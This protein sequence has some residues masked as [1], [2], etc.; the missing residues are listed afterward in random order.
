MEQAFGLIAAAIGMTILLTV[1]SG[2]I[3]LVFGA[4]ILGLAQSRFG[5][6]RVIY[7][8]FV[9]VVRGVPALVWL[10]ITFFGLAELGIVIPA[11]P[12]AIIAL[13]VIATAS[14]AEIYRGGLN[15]IRV[16]Q[17]EAGWAIGLSRFSLTKDVVFPQLLRAVSPTV[18]TYFVGLLKDSA[19]AS[20][21]GVSEI[22]FVTGQQVTSHGNGLT[23]YLFAGLL[24]LALSVPLGILSR[25]V[26]G[27]LARR[28]TVV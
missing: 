16:G 26:S 27:R 15:A 10:F 4:L 21:I 7:S 20:V 17:Y 1:V 2:G 5:V 6:F 22:V 12:S 28:Y 19:L 23:L 13:G 8:V 3:G 18:A 24:Y 14:M 25:S 11:L 9:H